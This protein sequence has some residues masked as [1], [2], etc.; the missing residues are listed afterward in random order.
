MEFITSKTL[1]VALVG[2]IALMCLEFRRRE[3]P[4]WFSNLWKIAKEDGPLFVF[5]CAA[6]L[7]G[8]YVDTYIVA[9]AALCILAVV[10]GH[11]MFVHIPVMRAVHQRIAE[12]GVWERNRVAEIDEAERIRNERLMQE[13]QRLDSAAVFISNRI[14][15]WPDVR[16]NLKSVNLNF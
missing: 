12:S 11:T 14:V 2:L 4:D 1:C 9:A 13:Y 6:S 16:R 5:A 3:G 8:F 7:L 10:L 15:F